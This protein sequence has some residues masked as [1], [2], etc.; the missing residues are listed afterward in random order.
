MPKSSPPSNLRPKILQ[1]SLTP[2]TVRPATPEVPPS[3]NPPPTLLEFVTS[4][5]PP[6]T[7]ELVALAPYIQVIRH[8]LEIVS[9]ESSWEESWLALGAWW[10][11]CLFSEAT[12]KF[13]MPL[14]M[15]FVCGLRK[16]SSY[17]GPSI[18]S[19]PATEATVHAVLSDLTTIHALVPSSP[20]T[21]LPL[22][23]SLTLFRLAA[24]TYLPYLIL[25]HFVPLHICIAITGTLVFIHRA[26]WARNTRATLARSAHLRW[27]YY[28]FRALLS[29]TPLPSPSSPPPSY[30]SRPI[31]GFSEYASATS[32]SVDVDE[33]APAQPVRFL[34]TV[35]ENQRW[36]M[37]LDWT[38]ALLP[39]E[40]PAWCSAA[41]VPLPPP[42]AFSLPPPTVSYVTVG[43][44]EARAK[45][46]ATWT[47]EE[48]EWRVVIKREGRE[49]VWRVEKSPPRDKD[50]SEDAAGAAARM[51][52][53]ARGRDSGRLAGPSNGPESD[54]AGEQHVDDPSAIA[55]AEDDSATDPEGWVYADN[56]WEGL[57][58]RGGI[59]KYT[60]YRRWTRIAKLTET[61]EVVGPGEVGVIRNSTD[62]KVPSMAT[63][64]N[65]LSPTRS[66]FSD[67]DSVVTAPESA[68]E[69]QSEAT[70]RQRLKAV[71]DGPGR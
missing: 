54:K 64:Y 51:L 53:A 25:T 68:K 60:R 21:D 23:P 71:V 52:R 40:R 65:R 9:W 28:H 37:G 33:P 48:P 16:W 63:S 66:S 35:Y 13:F 19:Q 67:L 56:K 2:A 34:F 6:L 70:L 15:L 17:D 36:W 18:S 41:Q 26:R 5:P 55:G 30:D 39:G 46:V 27:G 49:G 7:Y 29:G 38:A 3:P 10:A 45:R 47:W 61:V 11:L 1:M 8:L 62:F 44:G 22:P 57:S 32:R 31:S 43:N 12:L 24:F 4:T 42:A 59:G 58:S 14:A 20:F 50:T 69:T